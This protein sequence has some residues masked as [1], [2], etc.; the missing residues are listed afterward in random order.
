M[1]DD[2]NLAQTLGVSSNSSSSSLT[3]LS[4]CALRLG[5]PDA[6]EVAQ[7]C[8]HEGELTRGFGGTPGQHPHDP[9]SVPIGP[10]T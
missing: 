10:I 2:R 6:H 7:P 4:S 8:I 1:A 9:L 5:P 3:S